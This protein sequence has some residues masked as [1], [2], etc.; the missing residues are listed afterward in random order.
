MQNLILALLT[1]ISLKTT[2]SNEMKQKSKSEGLFQDKGD[3]TNLTY[4]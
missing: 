3:V 2:N 4:T 1:V